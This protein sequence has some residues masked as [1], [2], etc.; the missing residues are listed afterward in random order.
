M[1]LI[2]TILNRQVPGAGYEEM[3][4]LQ[5]GAADYPAG[6]YPYTP[7]LFG[8]STVDWIL[9]GQRAKGYLVTIDYDN[10]KIQV[11][12]SAGGALAEVAAATDLSGLALDVLVKGR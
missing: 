3:V 10:K 5:P 1:A 12:T 9:P 2:A 7:A 8:L 6:G 11:W 4:K